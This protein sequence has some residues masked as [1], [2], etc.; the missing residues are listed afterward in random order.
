MTPSLEPLGAFGDQLTVVSGAANVAGDP[1]DAGGRPRALV[2]GCDRRFSPVPRHPSLTRWSPS[3][4][5][6]LAAERVMAPRNTY[7]YRFIVD[8]R[9]VHI[10]ITIDLARRELEH[11]RRWPDG[12]IQKVGRATT[13]EADLAMGRGN[14]GNAGLVPSPDAHRAH[15]GTLARPASFFARPRGARPRTRHRRRL[16]AGT[17]TACASSHRR[18]RQRRSG[19]EVSTRPPQ[20]QPP[21]RVGTEP[22]CPRPHQYRAPHDAARRPLCRTTTRR[23]RATRS[24]STPYSCPN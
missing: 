5:L 4:I 11:R 24:T 14:K 6:D 16:Y 2:L 21:A 22:A 8:G 17:G 10:G 3:V 12:R 7:R 23:K 1:I 20:R 15:P 19:G 13:H 18:L 9:T